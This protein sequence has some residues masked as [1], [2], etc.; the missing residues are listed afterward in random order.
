MYILGSSSP[1]PCPGGSYCQFDGLYEPTAYCYAGFYCAGAATTGTPLDHVTGDICPAGHYCEAGS[2]WPDPC[3]LGTYSPNTANR[4]VTDCFL[5]DYGEYCGEYNLTG[6]S[7]KLITKSVTVEVQ[8][9]SLNLC[10]AGTV[11]SFKLNTMLL[12]LI[13]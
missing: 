9:F 2:P 12:K 3:P 4:N 13:K 8:V 6:T 11:Y 10:P 1:V 5:C 7:G